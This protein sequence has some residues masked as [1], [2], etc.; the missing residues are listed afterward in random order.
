MKAVLKMREAEQ[1]SDNSR[2]ASP[3]K[4]SWNS[5][6]AKPFL[7]CREGRVNKEPRGWGRRS[8]GNAE[9]GCGGRGVG[10]SSRNLNTV[11]SGYSDAVTAIKTQSWR[12]R[13]HK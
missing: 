8:D 3:G 7:T 11:R 6:V 10:T 9:R 5:M 1:R 2:P 4:E 13:E 12:A